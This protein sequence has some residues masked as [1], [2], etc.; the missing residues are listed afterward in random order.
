MIFHEVFPQQQIDPEKESVGIV[1]PYDQQRNALQELFYNTSVK[2]DTVDKFQGQEKDTIIISTVDNIITPFADNAQRMNVAISRAKKRLIL[3]TSSN[4]KENT[5]VQDLINYIEYNNY[6]VIESNTYSIF[7]NLYSS[8]SEHRKLLL[9]KSRKVSQYDSE[10]LT[11]MLIED[12]LKTD[13]FSKLSVTSHVPLRM[14]ISNFKKLSKSENKYVSNVLTHV[15]FLIF[16][17]LSKKPILV[18][19]V[20]GTSFHKKGSRQEVRDKMKNSI[21]LRYSIPLLRLATNESKEKERLISMLN[22]FC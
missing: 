4:Q 6:K 10:N 18:I 20:D 22:K 19:E 14:I 15:D 8:Y 1:T 12:T 21:L 16:E 17:K 7:D 5:N 13:R 3:V 9:K 2:A 11:Y